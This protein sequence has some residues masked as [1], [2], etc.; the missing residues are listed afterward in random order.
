MADAADAERWRPSLGQHV[1]VAGTGKWWKG[2]HFGAVIVDIRDSDATVKVRY[3]DGGFKRF[4]AEEFEALVRYQAGTPEMWEEWTASS[5]EDQKTELQRLHDGIMDAKRAKDVVEAA[6]LARQFEALAAKT[7]AIREL[8]V[9]LQDMVHT[10]DFLRAHEVQQHIRELEQGGQP[11]GSSPSLS[12]QASSSSPSSSSSSVISG[13]RLPGQEA[14][15]ADILQ[16]AAIRSLGGGLAGA[17]AMTV[18]VASLMWLRTTM[19]Y[20]YRYG[21]TTRE[22]MVT[23]YGEGGAA[24]F[25]RGFMPALLQSPLSRFGDTAANAGVLALFESTDARGWPTPVKTLFASAIA[26]GMRIALVPLDTVKTVLQVEGRAGL[27]VVAT[28]YTKG[29]APIFFHGSVATSAATFVGHYPWFTTFNTLNE[30]LPNYAERPKQLLRNAGIG[31]CASVCSDTVANS[32]RVMKTVRQTHET[33]SYGS[34]VRQV[35]KQDGIAGLLGR[36]LKTRIIANGLSGVMFSVLYRIFEE[37]LV[38]R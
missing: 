22:A 7:D 21:M 23:L 11:G 10:G 33:M 18:Q 27:Q 32:L 9:Q 24:R 19:N 13:F 20:Q 28:K 3:T 2:Q 38:V 29:G 14:P 17:G 31:F 35:V 12:S 36:G 37:R 8:Q 6:E 30:T 1:Y 4:R 34:I 25:Y 16:Q 15:L 5:C 26:A